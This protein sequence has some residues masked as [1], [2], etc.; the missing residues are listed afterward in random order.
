MKKL[1]AL[2]AAAILLFAS[3]ALAESPDLRSLTDEELAKLYMDVAEEV[4]RRW[5]EQTGEDISSWNT[6]PEPT[7]DPFEEAPV[8][9]SL[10]EFFTYWSAN[11][12]DHMLE[13]CASSWKEGE[14]YP[15]TS[16]FALL[17]NR[18][19]KDITFEKIVGDPAEGQVTV[20][21][22]STIDRNNGK[23]AILYRL[24][25]RM[26]R[27]ENGAWRLDPRS[28]VSEEM[29]RDPVEPTPDPTATPEGLTG[30]TLL[31]YVPGGGTYYHLNPNC[32]S[33]HGRYLPMEDC[34]PYAEVN[35]EAYRELEPCKLCKAPER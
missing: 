16:L 5:R 11:D 6:V 14:E 2:L 31:Y 19:P 18:T 30:D 21:V 15:R 7:P 12:L 10:G 25:L 29:A 35:D 24:E 9:D 13:Q 17:R 27:E 20:V 23:P 4:N 3:A 28:L 1:I 34:F 8:I 26:V 33:V 22:R 32:R